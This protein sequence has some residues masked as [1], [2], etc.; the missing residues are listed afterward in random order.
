MTVF[1]LPEEQTKEEF[2]AMLD[3]LG[4]TEDEAADLGWNKPTKQEVANAPAQTPKG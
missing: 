1:I 3:E 4:L 2:A